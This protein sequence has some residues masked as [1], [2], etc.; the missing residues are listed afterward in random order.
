VNEP[1][2]AK[3][4]HH[5]LS[6]LLG[7]ALVLLLVCAATLWWVVPSFL[8]PCGNDNIEEFPSPDGRMKAVRFRRD[9]GATTGYSTHVSLLPAGSKLGNE[10]GN[11]FVIREEPP[12]G[13]RWIDAHHLSI[14]SSGTATS[15][16]HL[17]KFEAIR[18]TY[19]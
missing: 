1:V 6:I 18:I 17:E 10:A 16:L 8:N 2:P 3:S 5:E 19:K 12:V 15:H 9:C 14:S 11:V 4:A 13:V 7:G